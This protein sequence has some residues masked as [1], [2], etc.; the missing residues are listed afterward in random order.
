MRVVPTFNAHASGVLNELNNPGR[1][2]VLTRWV[3]E[4]G[5]NIYFRLAWMNML[6]VTEVLRCPMSFDL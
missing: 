3:R 5:P 1:H 2:K 6:V 4:L